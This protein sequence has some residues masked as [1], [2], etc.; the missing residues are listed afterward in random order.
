MNIKATAENIR[1][2]FIEL[3]VDIPLEEIEERLNKLVTKFKVPEDEAQR[4]VVNY[5]LKE[6]N[7]S[8]NKFYSGQFEVQ[9]MSIDELNE[10][11][12]WVT[13]KGKIAQLW[14]NSHESISQVG[15]IGD[16]TGVI[17]FTKWK[18]A[19]LPDVEEGKNYLFKNVVVNEWNDKFQINL[20]R[21]SS[22]EEIEDEI[23]IGT[24]TVSFTGAMVDIQVGS[25]LIKRCPECNRALTKGACTEHGK[26]EGVY[27][28]RIKAVFDNGSTVQEAIIGRKLTEQLADITLDNAIAMAADALDQGVVME[29]IKGKLN[30]RYY[31]ISGSKMD[32]YIL[33]DEIT[34]GSKPDIGMID[35]LVARAEAV[36]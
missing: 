4:S 5:F 1:N 16:E 14:E 25:G 23:E 15:L 33:V 26:V 27:D 9:Q 24:S 2:K 6:H 21:T 11:G 31:S 13:V 10:D 3:D 17:K 22:I 36:V 18:N 29:H 8:K 19:D 7:I 12:K 20:N 30:G 28:L 32:R 34:K 35:E